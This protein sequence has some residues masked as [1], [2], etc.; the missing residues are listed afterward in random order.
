MIPVDASR[1]SLVPESSSLDVFLLGTVDLGSAIELQ[2]RLRR[3]VI[4]RTDSHGAILVC[5]HPP[6]I[7]IGRE[8]SFA[9]VLVDPSELI[10]RKMEVRWLNRGGGAFVH[11]P[12]QLSAYVVVPLERLKLGLLAFRSALEGSLVAT[13]ADLKVPAEPSKVMPGASCRCGQFAFIGAAVRDWVSYGG[14]HVNVSLAQEPLDLIRWSSSDV[15]MTSLSAQRT[16]PV[17]MSTVRESLIRNLAAALGYDGFHLYTGHPLLHRSSRK[18]Y[19]Y[20]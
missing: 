5:E 19:V 9:D 17:A 4:G 13:A 11:L 3:D 6:S 8:G 7:T 15:R 18:V 1:E 10:S 14:L 20:A 12:G 2:D 16:R